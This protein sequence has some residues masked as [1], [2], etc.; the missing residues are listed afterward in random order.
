MHEAIYEGGKKK[1][2]AEKVSAAP[3]I[4]LGATSPLLSLPRQS[5]SAPPCTA[6]GTRVPRLRLVW[7][8]QPSFGLPSW[9]LVLEGLLCLRSSAMRTHPGR[10]FQHQT[11]FL[12][13]CSNHP[14]HPHSM[15]QNKLCVFPSRYC[16]SE[17]HCLLSGLL[18]FLTPW[19]Y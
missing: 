12:M 1:Q 11:T 14:P 16:K 5:A 7:N 13:L 15:G 6:S 4:G 2:T 9:A 19:V 3:P 17:T 10:P 8:T 18:K